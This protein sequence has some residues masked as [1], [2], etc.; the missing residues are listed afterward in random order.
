MAADEET[1]C[2]PVGH[3]YEKDCNTCTCT[4]TGVTVCTE[5]ACY[6]GPTHEDTIKPTKIETQAICEPGETMKNVSIIL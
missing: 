2:S 3:Q 4:E 6:Y 5:R 1:K